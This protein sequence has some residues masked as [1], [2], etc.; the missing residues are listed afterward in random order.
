MVWPRLWRGRIGRREAP[1]TGFVAPAGAPRPAFHNRARGDLT[2]IPFAGRARVST[3]RTVCRGAPDLHELS[4]WWAGAG[5]AAAAAAPECEALL[6]EGGTLSM[7]A[8]HGRERAAG[9]RAGVEAGNDRLAGR[10]RQALSPGGG[11]AGQP[12]RLRCL[13]AKRLRRERRR[14]AGAGIVRL[15]LSM[16]LRCRVQD[17]TLEG[18]RLR[19]PAASFL[20]MAAAHR[21]GIHGAKRCNLSRPQPLR[22]RRRG[23][24]SRDAR[25]RRCDGSRSRPERRGGFHCPSREELDASYRFAW[26]S[27]VGKPLDLRL[28]RMRWESSLTLPWAD[29]ASAAMC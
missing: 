27:G 20:A 6:H 21:R 9:R 23:V 29:C 15:G 10:A 13:F 8:V 11:H 25:A 2:S 14:G 24:T 17:A 26:L 4:R 18:L 3:A 19:W 16:V 7:R 1:Q 22:A 28:P 12:G 5:F